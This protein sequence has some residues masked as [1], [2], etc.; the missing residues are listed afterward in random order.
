MIS[1][2]RADTGPL[3]SSEVVYATSQIMHVFQASGFAT[4]TSWPR[5][6]AADVQSADLYDSQCWQQVCLVINSNR[7]VWEHERQFQPTNVDQAEISRK[8]AHRACT[9]TL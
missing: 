9:D 3:D 5:Q 4:R 1:A 2:Q 6:G 8:T 7:I